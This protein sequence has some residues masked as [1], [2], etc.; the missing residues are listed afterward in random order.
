MYSPK[1]MIRAA[2]GGVLIALGLVAATPAE[3]YWRRW[4]PRPYVYVHP[5]PP[6][7]YAPPPVVYRPYP[8]RGYWVPGHYDRWGR[9][10]PPHWRY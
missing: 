6:L 10:V 2:V 4:G 5:R 8:Y 1:A 7:F 3:A 9:W